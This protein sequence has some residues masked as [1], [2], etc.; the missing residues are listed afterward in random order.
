MKRSPALF[1]FCAALS[2]A[3]LSCT[4]QRVFEDRPIVWRVYDDRNIDQPEEYHFNEYT[5]VADGVLIDPLDRTLALADESPARDTNAIDEVPDSSWFENRIGRY[6]LTAEDVARGPGGKPP[7]L[8]LV[9]TKGKSE[10]ANPGFIAKDADGRKFMIKFDKHQEISTGNAALVQRLMWAAGYHTTTET[11]I[12]VPRN[13]ISI[14]PKA[15]HDQGINEDLPF[16]PDILQTVLDR[17]DPGPT[18]DGVYRALASEFLPGK[19][20]GGT[21]DRG[22]RD[23]DPNDTIP[24]EHRRTLRGLKLFCAWVD[25]TD[26]RA[27]NMLDMF[28]EED[29]RK[30]VKHHQHDFGDTMGG[31]S[32]FSPWMGY[33]YVFDYEYNFLSLLSFGLWKR[34]WEDK[35]MRPFRSVGAYHAK[36]DVTGWRPAKP[37]YPFREMTDADAFWAA[38]IIMRFKR[39]HIEAAVAAGKFSDPAARGYLVETILARARSI[40]LVYMTDVTAVDLFDVKRDSVCMTD[41]AVHHNLVVGGVLERVVDGEVVER[42]SIG[43]DGRVCLKGPGDAEYEVYSLRVVRDGETLEPMELHVSGATT[44]RIRGVVRDW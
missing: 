18:P 16:T 36:F 4:S 33:S 22:V 43:K 32:V 6:D 39:E 40:G 11:V 14:D 5:Y 8:P 31:H 30:Y 3:T 37:F 27:A 10:G 2:C 44:P 20:L 17:A 12:G 13:Q 9:I 29:G 35:H 24:H 34:P 1:A 26:I 15:T 23:D 41:L 19:P 21:P 42:E 38:K 28:V 25:N 7:R